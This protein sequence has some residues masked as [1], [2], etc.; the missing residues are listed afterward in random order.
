MDVISLQKY[1]LN[2]STLTKEQMKRA[3]I[4]QD[5]EA[6]IFDLALLKRMVVNETAVE[7]Q[8]DAKFMPFQ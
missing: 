5:N 6:D 7:K 4:N 3:D 2:I 1:L 8:W